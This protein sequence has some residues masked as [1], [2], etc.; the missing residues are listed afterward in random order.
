MT[1]M[2]SLA[3]A[4]ERECRARTSV[5]EADLVPGLARNRERHP[6]ALEPQ[7]AHP[8]GRQRRG[9]ASPRAADDAWWKGRR[10]AVL[11]RASR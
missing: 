5:G 4:L 6:G 11:L 1:V 10:G 2:A 8:P 9:R 3:E 7:R